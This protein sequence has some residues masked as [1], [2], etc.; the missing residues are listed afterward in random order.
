MW[1]VLV[2]LNKMATPLVLCCSSSKSLRTPLQLHTPFFYRFFPY[3]IGFPM[4]LGTT[5]V[6]TVYL[7]ICHVALD[8][9]NG[10]TD[11]CININGS[12]VL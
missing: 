4:M 9:D 2:L 7:V 1:C 5:F 11:D 3:R 6:A 12:A 10:N 8:W